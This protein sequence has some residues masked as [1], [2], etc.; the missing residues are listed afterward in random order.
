MP[1]CS[2]RTRVESSFW[3]REDKARRT[4]S[5]ERSMNASVTLCAMPS[6]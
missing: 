6:G 2:R 1:N 4:G 5:Y 3:F